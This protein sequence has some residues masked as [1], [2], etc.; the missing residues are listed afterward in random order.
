MKV[1]DFFADGSASCSVFVSEPL[2]CTSHTTVASIRNYTLCCNCNYNCYTDFQ[3]RQTL[4]VTRIWIQ[5]GTVT[6]TK[7]LS[8]YSSVA[9]YNY[10]HKGMCLLKQHYFIAW[11]WWPQCNSH[12][13]AASL[14][15]SKPRRFHN[16]PG[17]STQV[18]PEVPL[19]I[20]S[21]G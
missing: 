2:V 16:T 10:Y 12:T 19:C 14:R 7:I 8:H 13:T 20:S 6:T 11:R 18:L 15:R 3:V 17:H 5:H 9:N 4:T 21:T 1:F